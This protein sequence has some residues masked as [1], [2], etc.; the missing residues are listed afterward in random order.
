M[1]MFAEASVRLEEDHNPDVSGDL[2]YMRKHATKAKV[3]W[4]C[5]GVLVCTVF[6]ASQTIANFAYPQ[7]DMA[8]QLTAA[9]IPGHGLKTYYPWF[10]EDTDGVTGWVSDRQFLRYTTF[11]L[12]LTIAIT[13]LGLEMVHIHACKHA[14]MHAHLRARVCS[15]TQRFVHMLDVEGHCSTWNI[16][17]HMCTTVH[18]STCPSIR[19]DDP[20]TTTHPSTTHPPCVPSSTRADM[21]VAHRYLVSHW[22][23]Q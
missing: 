10:K 1:E 13:G 6:A 22:W 14:R 15:Y 20:S 3:Y 7:L 18:S 19:E 23:Q 16:R 17:V 8:A 11:L 2:E 21:Q 9:D 12:T 4:G 5:T